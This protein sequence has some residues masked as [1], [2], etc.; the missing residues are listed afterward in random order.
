ML[1][2]RALSSADYPLL[3]RWLS[4]PHVDAWWHQPLDL[5]EVADK[6]GPRIDGTEPT[7]VFIVEDASY[8]IG[9]IQWYRWSDYPEHAER[10]NAGHG[11]AGIDLAIGERTL[12]GRGLGPQIIREFLQSH[13]WPQPGISSAVVDVDTRNQRSRRAFEKAGFSQTAT[14]RL[15]NEDMDRHVLRLR[16]YGLRS[17]TSDDRKFVEHVYFKTQRYIIEALFGWRGDEIERTNF[18]SFY[19]VAKSSIIIAGGQDIGWM[20]VARHSDHI[21]AQHLYLD[22]AHQGGGIGS[23]ILRDLIEEADTANL[24]LRVSTAKMNR[25][26]RFYE[27]FGFLEIGTDE[28]KVYMERLSGLTL[29]RVSAELADAFVVMRD[30]FL[31]AGDDDWKGGAAIAHTD[32]AGYLQTLRNWSEGQDLPPDW[33]TADCYLIFAGDVAIGQLDVRDSLTETLKQYGGNIGYSVHPAYRNRG[34]A[35]WALRTGLEMLARKG[36]TVA[37]LTC[38]DGNAASIRVIEKCGGRRIAD[39]VRR[40]YLISI[41]R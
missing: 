23:A 5:A 40:R 13:V 14:V 1:S 31:A 27:R 28:F 6:Y 33:S 9:F 32:P 38:A 15:R 4:E 39:S 16:A 37:L 3:Q 21:E 25:A 26:R 17:A 2:F 8:P 30:A 20:T 18:A 10:L 7:H 34:I 35:T 36:L 24:P 41:P 22:E 19:D 11:A 12:I 29:K